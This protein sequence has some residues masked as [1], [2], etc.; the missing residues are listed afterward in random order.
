MEVAF[1]RYGTVY[2]YDAKTLWTAYGVALLVAGLAVLMGTTALWLNG[3]AYDN[4]FSTVLRATYID[5][6][7]ASRSEA[8]HNRSTDRV[9]DGSRPLPKAL[10]RAIVVVRSSS[11]NRKTDLELRDSSGAPPQSDDASGVE[12]SLLHTSK[13]HTL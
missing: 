7:G 11:R 4:T 1:E 12:A 6:P 3:V 9:D 8:L 2:R 13:R 10:A 5:G